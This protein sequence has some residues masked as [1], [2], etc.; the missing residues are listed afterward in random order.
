VL[1]DQVVVLLVGELYTPR[2]TARK[3]MRIDRK[4]VSAERS[5]CGNGVKCGRSPVLLIVHTR[6]K[7]RTAASHTQT[8]PTQPPQSISGCASLG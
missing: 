2:S 4:E 1:L 3:Q 8:H 5:I 6:H 7:V